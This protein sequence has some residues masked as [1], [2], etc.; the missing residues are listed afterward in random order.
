[1][2][3][4]SDVHSSVREFTGR[5]WSI[6]SSRQVGAGRYLYPPFPDNVSRNFAKIK[7]QPVAPGEVFSACSTSLFTTGSKGYIL[8]DD[9]LYSSKHG[10]IPY[11]AAA[12]L[13]VAFSLDRREDK[14]KFS[15]AAK[16]GDVVLNDLYDAGAAVVAQDYYRRLCSRNFDITDQDI[17]DLIRPRLAGFD[18]TLTYSNFGSL[19]LISLC[20][21]RPG[22]SVLGTSK[23]LLFTNERLF[24]LEHGSVAE[25]FN[26]TDVKYIQLS[27]YRTRVRLDMLGAALKEAAKLLISF[28]DSVSTSSNIKVKVAN[29]RTFD[30]LNV[31]AEEAD[32]VV[33]AAARAGVEI[34]KA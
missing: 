31:A 4:F 32:E 18:G 26:Y 16:Y 30:L 33:K 27:K 2:Q 12:D 24:R 22:E 9:C 7:G 11:T 17:D 25:Y 23:D 1:M 28:V 20:G 13:Q 19:T 8:T 21:L 6:I 14:V 10:R 15:G 34:R 29:W 5:Y 3:T